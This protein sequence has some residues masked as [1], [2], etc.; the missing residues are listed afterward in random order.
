MT[1]AF[2]IEFSDKAQ[3]YVVTNE[4]SRLTVGEFC[5]REEAEWCVDNIE[6]RIAREQSRQQALW[7]YVR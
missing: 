4:Q 2:K 5:Y 7:T 1:P 6:R 3:K